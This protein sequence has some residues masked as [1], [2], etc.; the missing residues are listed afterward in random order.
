[1]EYKI[2]V[3]VYKSHLNHNE[4]LV[5]KNILALYGKGNLVIACP[6]NL[7]VDFLDQDIK[8]QRFDSVFFKDVMS[9]NAM[10]LSEIFYMRFKNTDYILIHQLDAFMFRKEIEY[11]CQKGYD[12]IGAPWLKSRN[13]FNNLIKSKKLKKREPIFNKVGNGGFSLRKVETFLGFFE[14]HKSVIEKHKSH[15]LYG[16]EDTF[17]SL[18]APNYMEFNIPDIKE[19]AQFCIDR[20]PEIGLKLNKGK[21]PFACHGFEKSKTKAFWQKHIKGLK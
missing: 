1:M 16:I 2:V 10:M 14:K 6:D 15:E 8:I 4:D 21:L 9:Y 12:Y 7:N 19:A 17:W 13:P 18:V 3:P 20:K 5:F 11:W